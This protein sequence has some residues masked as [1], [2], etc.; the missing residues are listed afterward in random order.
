MVAKLG[1]V[2]KL[3]SSEAHACN[4]YD[5]LILVRLIR[6]FLKFKNS[7]KLF[8]SLV[9]TPSYLES[10][11]NMKLHR[12]FLRELYFQLKDSPCI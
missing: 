11:N 5:D 10:K 3:T 9:N 4:L 8:L 2:Q 6:L 12:P 1:N 7:L